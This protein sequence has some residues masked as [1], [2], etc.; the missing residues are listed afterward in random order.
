MWGK[1][2]PG[3]RRDR[4]G[5]CAKAELEQTRQLLASSVAR[6]YWD[7]QTQA[8]VEEVLTQI[9]SQQDN[10]IGAD[11]ELYQHGITSSVE[12]VE[13]DISASKTEEQI[14]EVHGKMK[15]IE[16]RLTR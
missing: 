5:E 13:T 4:Q 12:G 1:I 14:A 10:I 2:A 11:R 8:A 9:K 3:W 16:A 7:W 6:L 15:A